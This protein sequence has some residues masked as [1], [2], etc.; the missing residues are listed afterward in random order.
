[1]TQRGINGE[2]NNPETLIVIVNRK[3]EPLSE[4]DKQRCIEHIIEVHER[5]VG[6]P[7]PVPLERATF[8]VINLRE[9]DQIEDEGMPERLFEFLKNRT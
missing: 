3:W 2:F 1:L 7:N 6:H 9:Q 8:F 5:D 4:N